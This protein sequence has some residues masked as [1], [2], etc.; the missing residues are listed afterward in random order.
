MSD[1]GLP[2]EGLYEDAK[3]LVH[4]VGKPI[5]KPLSDWWQRREYLRSFAPEF[6]KHPP[7]ASDIVNYF[8]WHEDEKDWRTNKGIV[9]SCSYGE[10]LRLWTVP[11]H[12]VTYEARLLRFLRSGGEV[13][14]VF[15]V[16]P[17]LADPVRVWAL[18]RTLLR[19]HMLGFQPRVQSVLDLRQ[20]L[21]ELGINCH[22]G[23]SINGEIAYFFRFSENVQPLMVRT[24]VEHIARR[25]ETLF[26]DLWRKAEG[27]DNWYSGQR[28]K[29]P[30]ELLTQVELDVEAVEHVAGTA[31][32][33]SPAPDGWRRR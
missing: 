3:R 15:F 2:T 19:H 28:W 21:R 4:A 25:A 11:E 27:F 7:G 10:V 13:R 8:Q 32:N 1:L 5:L 29:L 12:F 33:L 31:P 20:G 30:E 18:E 26:G 9:F 23:G 24:T 14:R 22:M 17:D 6:A 16:G